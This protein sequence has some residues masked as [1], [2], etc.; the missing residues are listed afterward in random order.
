MLPQLYHAHHCRYLDDLPFW[1]DLAAQS[2]DPILELGCGTGRVLI[3]LAK[4]GYQTVGLDR[5]RSM[6]KFAHLNIGQEI[7]PEP[8]LVAADI[9]EFNLTIHFPL[10]ILPCN[11]FSTLSHDHR[12]ACLRCVHRH[13]RQGGIFAVSVPN[14]ELLIRLPSRSMTELEDEF[15][16]PDTGNPVQV[17]SSWKRTKD[18]FN[19]TWIYDHLLPDG[20]VDRLEIN[21]I[22]QI[23]PLGIYLSEIENAGLMVTDLYGDFDHS[24]YKEDSPY[25]LILAG[26]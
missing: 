18:N 14:P 15:V 26:H 8:R 23:T 19:V 13:L 12:R 16:H 25:L 2:G 10:I 24:S 9:G 11:T 5:D 21:A 22:H 4:E 20:T 1:L 6:L 7:K 17:S 3:P